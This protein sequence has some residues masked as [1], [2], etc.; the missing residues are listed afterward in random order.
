MSGQVKPERISRRRL[1]QGAALVIGV[2]LVRRKAGAAETSDS[3]LAEIGELDG[4]ASKFSGFAP[5][6]FVRI[7]ADGRIV[8]IMPSAEM[9]QG[10]YTA[11]A[12][13]IAE[14]LEVG[15][16]QLEVV[17][18]PVSV[19]YTQPLFKA[20]L[21]GGS[22]STRGFWLPLRQAGAS[23]RMMLTTA[24]AAQWGVAPGECVC[25]R[26]TVTHPPSGRMLG[27]GALVPA[28][29]LLPVPKNAPLKPQS[30]F[31]LIG[32][33]AKRLD[34]PA[35]VNGS[36]VFGIDVVVPGMKI[37]AIAMCPVTGGRLRGLDDRAT[38]Q[39]PGVVDVL[40]IDNAVV[41]VG[42]NYWAARAGLEALVIDWDPGPNA[43]MSSASIRA[44]QVQAAGSGTPIPGVHRGDADAGLAGAAAKVEA[45]YEMP[46]LAHAT[47]EPIN[48][49]VHVRSDGCDIWVG[50]QA[51]VVARRHAARI[52]GLPPECI[53][54]HNHL[55]GG[56]FGRRLQADT[57]DQAVAFAKQV[58]Y[59]L[60]IIWTREQDIQHD[61]FRPSYYDQI[62]AGLDAEGRPVAWTHRITSGTVRKYFNEGGWP[63]GKLDDD[64]LK[65]A[66]DM[67]YNFP[68]VRIDWVR[69]DPPVPLNWWR[70]VGA[71]HN[72]FVVE[73]FVDELAHAAEQDPVAYRRQLLAGNPRSLAVVNLAAEKSAW[74]E[75]CAARIGRGISVHDSFGT[76]AALVVEVA[77]APT[78]EVV[79]RRIV[80]AIDAGI[81]INPDTIRAQIEGGVLFGISA[82]LYNGVT[83]ADGVPQQSNF[84]DYR[85][86]RIDEVP[87]IE[88]YLVPSGASPG[89]MGEVGTISAAPALTNAVFA[90]TGV[91][92]RSL[93][94]DR[95]AL[96]IGS[97]S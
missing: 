79:L 8:L 2:A 41:V 40:R 36:A 59:P 29:R 81:E 28:A 54:V 68:A 30:Q 42:E 24:A 88:V 57:I 70:G 56:G 14:E 7:G 47:L 62:A 22:T 34:T 77:V 48:T 25:D 4:M 23:A 95:G 96:A 80:A 53:N 75:P 92:L 91:R 39:L 89:G 87:P 52:T 55:I 17:A 86:L 10:I 11:E 31:K 78:G 63:Q 32:R 94:L 82:A 76:H 21:T 60:K 6:G 3:E 66:I 33:P 58:D 97:L 50:T 49:T 15:L 5:G 74:G 61:R 71:V 83:F 12:M 27:Y 13:L 51:P 35:K 43:E 16:D 90:A 73:S 18:A 44:A 69:E 67:P 37:G 19:L 84:H 64:A 1:F 45:V 26:A 46:F 9:G 65:G 93:P 72:V 20:Q 38:R 85:Q